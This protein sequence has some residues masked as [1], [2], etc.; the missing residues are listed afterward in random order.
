MA[1]DGG[2]Y[3]Y[4]GNLGAW[5][6]HQRQARSSKTRPLKM[7]VGRESSEAL[8]QVLVDEGNFLLFVDCSDIQLTADLK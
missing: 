3:F 7:S 6:N 8:L 4:E 2:D 5:V 1:D